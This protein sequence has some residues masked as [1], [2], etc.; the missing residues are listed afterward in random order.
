MANEEKFSE[1]IAELQQARIKHNPE[2][3]LAITKLADSRI[4][5]LETGNTKAG[6]QHIRGNHENDFEKRGISLNQ[7]PDVTI[8]AIA[9]GKV[10][11]KQGATRTI[12][13]VAFEGKTQYIS[14]DV[15]NN[16][17][18]VGANPT[19]RRLIRRLTQGKSSWPKKLNSWQN[20]NTLLCGI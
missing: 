11:G 7:I 1:L 16:G 20:T 5:F 12:Y 13:E 6:L 2:N 4:V 18:I 19:P 14:V 10:L 17:Y 3:I 15:G 8:K 9:Q